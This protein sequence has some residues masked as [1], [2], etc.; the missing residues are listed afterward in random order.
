MTKKKRCRRLRRHY[1]AEGEIKDSLFAGTKSGEQGRKEQSDLWYVIQVQARHEIAV[2]EK[3]HARNVLLPGEDVFT[4][5]SERMVKESGEW[6]KKTE[7][8]FQKYIFAETEDTDGFRIRLR[9]IEEM[10]RMLRVDDKIVPI[11]PEE[12][13]LL[14]K[15]GGAGHVIRYSEGYMA[16]EKLVVTEGPMKGMEGLVK[17]TDRH[18]RIAGI[19]MDL[20][21]QKVTVRMGVGILKRISE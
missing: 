9:K 6:K 8:A 20:I 18:Q 12:Q 5:L 13:E 1:R 19:E 4:I 2:V 21:G 10:A 11:Y 17:W 3:C 14:Q 7:V 16:G 15:L